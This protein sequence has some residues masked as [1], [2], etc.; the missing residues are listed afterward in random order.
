MQLHPSYIPVT[1]QLHADRRINNEMSKSVASY[2]QMLKVRFLQKKRCEN[3]H[4]SKIR[5]KFAMSS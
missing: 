1:S 5:L 4:V 3:L 2:R